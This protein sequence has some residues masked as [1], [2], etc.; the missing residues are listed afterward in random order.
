MT[1]PDTL[2][3]PLCNN[4][5]AKH[6][7]SLICENQHTYDIARSGYINLLPVN[8][9]SS[10]N[11]GD[12]KE[13]VA[14][15]ANFL[16]QNHYL[17]I[18]TKI[19]TFIA[20]KIATATLTQSS[21]SADSGIQR[22]ID[23]GIPL[24]TSK[25]PLSILDAG[26]GEGY[27]L[28][29]I[30][31]YFNA[32]VNCL[33]IDISKAAIHAAAKRSKEICWCVASIYHLPI[34]DHS[35]DLIINIFSPYDFTELLRV[36]KKD[37]IIILVIPNDKHLI[38]IKNLVYKNQQNYTS[39]ERL[40]C[41]LQEHPNLSIINTE[42]VTYNFNLANQE[43]I[44]NLFAMTPFYWKSSQDI[45]KILADKESMQVTVD[46]KIVFLKQM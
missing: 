30:K 25:I 42:Q 22:N 13:M 17:P 9:K 31:N 45:Q 27:Y 21:S 20:A 12:S 2:K 34:I 37:A 40:L 38:E 39:N 24:K 43:A 41:K 7:Q 35:Q 29:K 15:R 23:S 1:I 4:S 3:C 11:P 6:E 10:K 16:N 26:C 32:S 5:L 46:V 18:I 19:N 14:A 8:E 36:A 33:G 44:K 28:T